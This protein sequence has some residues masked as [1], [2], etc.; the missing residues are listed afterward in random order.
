M[1]MISLNLRTLFFIYLFSPGNLYSLQFVSNQLIPGMTYFNWVWDHAVVIE[2][3]ILFHLFSMPYPFS[4]LSKTLYHIPICAVLLQ[5]S[6]CVLVLTLTNDKTT[7]LPWPKLL[8]RVDRLWLGWGTLWAGTVDES[9]TLKRVEKHALILGEVSVT[10]FLLLCLS[11]TT[12]TQLHPR[13]RVCRFRILAQTYPKISPQW[14]VFGK[15]FSVSWRSFLCV[16][17]HE[18]EIPPLKTLAAMQIRIFFHITF[19]YIT[20]VPKSDPRNFSAC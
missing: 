20:H 16:K 7:S 18:I 2:I 10:L 6:C 11:R 5:G 12:S 8:P 17:Q 9:Q 3:V 19:R 13:I 1:E 4:I 14:Y 15:H